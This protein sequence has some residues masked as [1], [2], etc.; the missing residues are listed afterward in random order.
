MMS[1]TSMMTS[2]VRLCRKLTTSSRVGHNT[3]REQPINGYYVMYGFIY[4]IF[5]KFYLLM[6]C[7][8]YPEFEEEI[9]HTNKLIVAAKEKELPPFESVTGKFVFFLF[10]LVLT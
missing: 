4:F 2:G 6:I 10:S 9:E 5:M 8:R 3:H 7:C 1:R